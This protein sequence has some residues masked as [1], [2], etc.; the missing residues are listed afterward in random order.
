MSAKPHLRAK[1]DAIVRLAADGVPVPQI[2]RIVG[3]CVSGVRKYCARNGISVADVKNVFQRKR[4]EF[5][6]AAVTE[7]SAA[8]LAEALGVS[9]ATIRKWAGLCNIELVDEYHKGFCVT[10]NGYRC[11]PAPGHPNADSK[12]YVRE[13]ILVMEAHIGRYLEPDECVHHID[14]DKLNNA[15]ANLELMTL[16]EHAALHAREGDTGWAVLHQRNKI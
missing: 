14:R 10:H 3:A 15:I 5:E 1:H 7:R 16:S 8:R 6:A 4:A 12:G 13:H 9:Q 2:A 11:L